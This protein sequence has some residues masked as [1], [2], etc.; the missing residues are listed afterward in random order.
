MEPVFGS[1]VLRTTV[2]GES[3]EKDDGKKKEKNDN[4]NHKR[5][6]RAKK[7]DKLTTRRGDTPKKKTFTYVYLFKKTKTQTGRRK[8]LLF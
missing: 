6:T 2:S 5:A 7:I 4:V 8:L 3:G 1:H